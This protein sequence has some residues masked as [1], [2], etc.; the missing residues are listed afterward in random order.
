[1]DP[2]FAHRI[3]LPNGLGFEVPSRSEWLAARLF[4]WEIFRWRCYAPP[5]FELRPDDTVVDVGAN[6]GLFALWAAPQVPRGRLISIEPTTAFEFLERNVKRGRLVNVS[7]LRLA[8]GR[9]EGAIELVSYRSV[10]ALSHRADLRPHRIHRMLLRGLGARGLE[11][12]RVSV[13]CRPLE[14]ILASQGVD[15]VD[16]LKLDCEGSEFEIVRSLSTE[17]LARIGRIAIEFHEF[18][19]DYRAEDLAAHL[20][21]HGFA[22]T[23]RGGRLRRR[24]VGTGML[25]AQRRSRSC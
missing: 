24:L 10:S 16:F 22:V 14:Q 19:A 25:F 6:L 4:V 9:E 15:R 21:H 11:T 1:M 5:G 23:R 20:E 2:D 8:A 3:G 17:A 13:P 12:R 18:R 7:P